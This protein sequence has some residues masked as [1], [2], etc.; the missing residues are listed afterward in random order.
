MPISQYIAVHFRKIPTKSL[1]PTRL[2]SKS[3]LCPPKTFC[4]TILT[5]LN[6]VFYRLEYFYLNACIG[7]LE[8]LF[9]N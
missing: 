8:R 6:A 9:E 3:K 1:L 2:Y 7:E 4:E 5:P